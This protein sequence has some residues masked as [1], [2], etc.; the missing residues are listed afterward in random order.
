M[1][2]KVLQNM[3]HVE[4]WEKIFDIMNDGM[5][6]TNAE[7]LTLKVN[8]AYE[9]ITGLD[10]KNL[11]GKYMSDIVK[12]GYLSTSITQQVIK[13]QKS[14]TIEQQIINGKKVALRG[15][16]IFEEGTIKMV[17][18]FVRDISVINKMQQELNHSKV[19]IAQYQKQLNDLQKNSFIAESPE[20]KKVIFIA[21]KVANVDS[22][23]LILGESGTGKEI[24]AKEI[25][26][27]SNRCKNLF[28]KINCGAIPEQ[29]LES[30]LF[31]YEGGAFTGA[32]K[33]GHIGI[34]EMANKGTVFLDEIGDMPLH[35]QVKLLRVLQEKTITRIGSTKSISIDTRVIAA[36]N[37]NIAEMVQKKEFR[38]DLYYRLNV[39]SIEIPPLRKRKTYII[40]LIDHFVKKFNQKYQL[41]KRLSPNLLKYFVEYDWPGNVRELENIIERILVLS[42][43]CEI[44]YSPSLL[45]WTS[46]TEQQQKE[47]KTIFS[48]EQYENISLKEAYEKVE[49]MLLQRASEKYKTTYEI[50]EALQISQPSVSRKLKKYNITKKC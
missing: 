41:Q 23:V 29:L 16:P 6:I 12:Q 4:D 48:T 38:Q 39:V 26:E 43:E 3:E 45:P 49:C 42:E 31:G 19:I 20:F 22:T 32:K 34:F 21:Q 50:A 14:I 10:S 8:Q 11:I 2:K 40:P 33:N 25:H 9:Q 15:I 1:K 28:L 46:E 7:G 17:V 47:N 36:T 13:T 37:Q 24:V 44:C 18:S 27:K 30:E 35:L 5:Y